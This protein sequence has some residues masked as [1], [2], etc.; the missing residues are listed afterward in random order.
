MTKNLNLN[1]NMQNNRFNIKHRVFE[2]NFIY[3]TF[4]NFLTL[5]FSMIPS[6][7]HIFDKKKFKDLS[8]NHLIYL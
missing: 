5:L 7:I 2:L 3:L 6:T 4:L 8:P 1:I